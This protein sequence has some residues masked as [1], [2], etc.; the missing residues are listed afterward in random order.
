M[1]AD[2]DG[3]G[4]KGSARQTHCPVAWGMLRE[5][6]RRPKQTA[7]SEV[8]GFEEGRLAAA[9]FGKAILVCAEMR[10]LG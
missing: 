9:P 4:G 5:T 2:G 10:F 8:Y 1:I 7:G 6:S 3:S